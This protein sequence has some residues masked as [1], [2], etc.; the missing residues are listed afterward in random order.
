MILLYAVMM[1]SVYSP[2]GE[3]VC[4]HVGVHM[5]LYGGIKGAYFHVSLCES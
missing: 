1:S 2:C 5:S 3:G 4:G